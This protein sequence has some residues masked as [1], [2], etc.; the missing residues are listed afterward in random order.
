[1]AQTGMHALPSEGNRW[2][3]LRIKDDPVK[4]SNRRGT[5]S[6]AM[7]GRNTRTTQIFFN[8]GRMR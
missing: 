8:T 2:R 7:A 4:E 3:N 5:V 1:M 6:F